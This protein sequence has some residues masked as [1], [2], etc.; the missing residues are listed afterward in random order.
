[1]RDKA[2][3]ALNASDPVGD[4]DSFFDHD[5]LL[6]GYNLIYGRSGCMSPS[7]RLKTTITNR[8]FL[9]FMLIPP[10]GANLR[11][12]KGWVSPRFVLKM[13][14]LDSFWSGLGIKA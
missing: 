12:L 13:I 6:S 8:F 2:K 10:R 9:N 5:R 3:P 1:M 4:K 7:S 11:P 14:I